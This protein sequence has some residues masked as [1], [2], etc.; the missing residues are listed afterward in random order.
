ML[1]EEEIPMTD[2]RTSAPRLLAATLALCFAVVLAACG[3]G[4]EEAAAPAEPTR[5]ESPEVGIAVEVPASS[6]F[7]AQ[8]TE[9]GVLRLASEGERAD[10]GVDL[11]PATVVYDA[12]P[13][14]VAGINLVEAVNQRKA[15]L[16]ARPNGRFYGQAELGG[17]LGTAYSTRGVY[18]EGGEEVEEVR[19]FAIHPQGDRLLHVTLR[20]VPVQGQGP[21]RVDQA[22]RAFGWIEP[23]EAAGAE[24]G[25]ELGTAVEGGTE[26][27]GA[28]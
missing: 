15:E 11:G 7:R 12:E 24:G 2:P 18:S 21:A 17:P 20:Y 23:L 8:G 28:S 1:G 6:S 25:E 19:I 27:E 9:G 13:P 16:E 4:A 10:S 22:M 14:Q 5:L 3:D 26:V